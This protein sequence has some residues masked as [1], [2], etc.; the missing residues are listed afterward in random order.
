MNIVARRK[1]REY[2]KFLQKVAD[3]INDEDDNNLIDFSKI[4]RAISKFQTI[5]KLDVD[6]MHFA[7]DVIW[8]ELGFDEHTD[9]FKVK[10]KF[11]SYCHSFHKVHRNSNKHCF[12]S[13]NF[14]PLIVKRIR[15]FKKN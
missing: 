15:G 8:N 13:M 12:S 7:I 3:L 5:G 1:N 10:F 2:H 11:N 9:A 4:Q 6:N 14:I